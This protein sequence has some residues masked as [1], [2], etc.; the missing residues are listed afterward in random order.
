VGSNGVPGLVGSDQ[1]GG[2]LHCFA[3]L[4]AFTAALP[5]FVS[6]HAQGVQLRFLR[7]DARRASMAA[8]LA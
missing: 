8:L 1:G 3:A 7:V 5:A 6:R 2:I 4:T